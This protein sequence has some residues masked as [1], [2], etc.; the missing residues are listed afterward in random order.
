MRGLFA[1]VLLGSFCAAAD[2]EQLLMAY[3]ADPSNW[4]IA[5][6]VALAY[7][8]RNQFTEAADYYRKALIGNPGFLPA[9]KNLG[10]VLWFAG[11]RGEA[12]TVF[13]HVLPQIPQDPV[14]HLYLGLADHGRSQYIDARRHF[15]AA[16]DLALSNP[17]FLPE[18]AESYLAAKDQSVLSRAAAMLASA[19][20]VDLT[21][22]TAEVLDRYGAAEAAYAA[23]R[24][25]L[26]FGATEPLYRAFAAFASTHQNNAYAI[27]IVNRGLRQFPASAALF[28]QRGL[29]AALE[30]DRESALRDF[31]AAAKADAR[32]AL[33]E[34]AAGVIELEEGRTSEAAA[35]F[36]RVLRQ[37]PDDAH[38]LYL[39][40]LALNRTGDA[41]THTEQ[42]DLLGRALR[43]HPND[44]R[45]LA[46][47]GQVYLA[48][49][50]LQ[51]GISRLTQA[52]S[53]D[54]KNA[55][56]HYQLALA[57]RRSGQTAAANR[58]MA[59]FR[60]LRSAVSAKQETE[61]V[62]FLK[63]QR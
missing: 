3:R 28:L 18:V 10:V 57:L 32:W 12:E 8:E 34:L 21:L 59:R 5:H 14:P 29:L 48:S 56:A 60:E 20:N 62:Q 4:K 63:V 52:V 43:V 50:R 35:T 36:A 58:Y 6:Q 42:I 1:L 24:D 31:Q 39:R 37:H 49:G 25:A 15:A 45:A 38:A 11:Q 61:L 2:L 47:L 55:T 13:R 53:A 26:G 17:D 30:G 7:T 27:E 19:R 23:Y 41:S 46:L 40:A 22:R 33:P 51:E 9:R 16:G 54:P 44:G